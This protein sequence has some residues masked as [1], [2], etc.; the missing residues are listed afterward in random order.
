MVL[1][2][3]LGIS[4][5]RLSESKN[6]PSLIGNM[7]D[8]WTRFFSS[9]R[10]P[11]RWQWWDGSGNVLDAAGPSDEFQ[12][13]ELFIFGLLLRIQRLDW[14]AP[15]WNIPAASWAPRCAACPCIFPCFD[16]AFPC[17]MTFL[18]TC[19]SFFNTNKNSTEENS[20]CGNSPRKC[21]LNIS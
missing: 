7:E 19:Y 12:C 3:W 6:E 17:L 21:H 15:C 11:K 5:P 1:R 4:Q 14:L 18:L 10:P 13:L 16:H 2:L 8:L 9:W 20:V